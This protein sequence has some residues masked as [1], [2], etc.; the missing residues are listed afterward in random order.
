MVLSEIRQQMVIATAIPQV[1]SENIMEKTQHAPRPFV[2]IRVEN[3]KVINETTK[4]N[5]S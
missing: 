1:Y 5:R 3:G 2:F 4:A